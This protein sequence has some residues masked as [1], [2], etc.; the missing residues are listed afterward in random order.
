MIPHSADPPENSAWI[1]GGGEVRKWLLV[2]HVKVTEDVRGLPCTHGEKIS[3]ISSPATYHIIPTTVTPCFLSL[4]MIGYCYQL[5]TYSTTTPRKSLPDN[6][7]Q[8]SPS[9]DHLISECKLLQCP[10]TIPHI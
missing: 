5:Q 2:N 1:S 9:S 3:Q 4:V 8:K 10:I 6:P 7:G